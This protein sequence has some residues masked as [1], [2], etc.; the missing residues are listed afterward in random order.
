MSLPR[1]LRP[2]AVLA[3]IAAA[4]ATLVAPLGA[5]AAPADQR[6]VVTFKDG[7][8]VAVRAAIARAGGR[9]VVDLSDVN[10]VAVRLPAAAVAALRRNGNVASVEEDPVRFALG[11][12]GG[13][14]KRAP[15]RAT[16]AAGGAVVPYGIDMVQATQLAVGATPPK[17]CII[18]SGYYLDHPNLQKTGVTGKDFT[19]SGVGDWNTDENSHGTHVAGT[20]AGVGV[21]GGV[22]GV[23]PG[24]ALQLHIAKVFDASG[25]AS[26]STIL[27]GVLDC[28]KSGAKVVNMSLGGGRPTNFEQRI[29]DFVSTKR[30]VLVIA[31]AG[32]DGDTTTSYPAGYAS[33]M[34]VAAVDSAKAVA[35]FS[36]QNADVEI[37]APG[38]GVL[39]TVMPN[40]ASKGSLTVGGNP[41]ASQAMDGS[42][43]ASA[44]GALA[45]FGLGDVP[46]AGSM[47]GK[48][49]LISRGSIS[50]A[51]KVLNCQTSGGVGAVI[52]NNTAGELF[53]TMGEVATAIPS[54]GITQAD[55]TALLAQAG[56]STTVG[57]VPDP[58]LYLEYNG[59][60]MATPHVA[61][62]AALVWSHFPACGPSRIREAL[63]ATAQDL[64]APGRDVAFGFGLVQAKAAR[65]WLA[66][67]GCAAN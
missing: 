6:V 24:G 23:V 67:N 2:R 25:S 41:V 7:A 58:A 26:S 15:L 66:A 30:G 56:A 11:Q 52:Y 35:S 37:A 21:D 65:D 63:N 22:V 36:Q 9:V 49:C 43:R 14:A 51:D 1:T 28:A 5:Q 29:Y 50:F 4:A 55:G 31:A 45:D 20:I 42:P 10:A 3:V 53:G 57:V 8:G 33:V 34:S 47:A 27:R 54:V 64:G 13:S 44:T 46:A 40:V 19:N 61:G 60:S 12:R 18:D 59:T 16:A 48:V 17:V 32:N 62:V 38:V 39:S